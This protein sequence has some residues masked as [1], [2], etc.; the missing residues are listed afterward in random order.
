MARITYTKTIENYNFSIPS[1]ISEEQYIF[2]KIELQNNPNTPLIDE[3]TI[4][5]SHDKLT[6]VLVIGI[7]VFIIGLFGMFAFETPQWWGGILMI[8][9]AFGVLHP[10][11]NMG[12]L[13]SS[14]NKLIVEQKRIEYFRALKIILLNSSNYDNF[15]M[16][17][18][19]KFVL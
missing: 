9:S 5:K 7:I 8:I 15:K 14:R 19:N 12:Q 11:V 13:E 2:M 18:R 10:I 4:Q 16:N 6:T 3:N 17:Y 1:F